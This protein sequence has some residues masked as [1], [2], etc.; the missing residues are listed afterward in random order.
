MGLVWNDQRVQILRNMIAAGCGGTE[1]AEALG[2]T[3]NAIIG[4]AT[5]LKIVRPFRTTPIVGR[6]RREPAKPNAA[7]A[8]RIKQRAA[9]AIASNVVVM[10]APLSAAVVD[11]APARAPGRI[12]LLDLTPTS[13]RWPSGNPREPDFSFCGA[14][15]LDGSPYCPFHTRLAYIPAQQRRRSA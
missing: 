9:A 11:Q 8:K 7:R 15:S 12:S 10:A 6:R 3:R 2:C 13:C 4:K 14:S 1:I 5:R